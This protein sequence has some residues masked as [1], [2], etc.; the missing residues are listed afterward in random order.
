MSPKGLV[1]SFYNRL[2]K[3]VLE[4][5]YT[6]MNTEI[7]NYTPMI[8]A[9]NYWIFKH[10]GN[11]RT[12]PQNFVAYKYKAGSSESP[13][14]LFC[15]YPPAEKL[16]VSKMTGYSGIGYLKTDRAI[17]M[18]TEMKPATGNSFVAVKWK[19][20]NI[21]LNLADFQSAEGEFYTKAGEEIEKEQNKPAKIKESEC[22]RIEH[23]IAVEKKRML[24]EQQD[25]LSKT[26]R[27]N[28]L[29]DSKVKNAMAA[30]QDPTR[31][32]IQNRLETELRLCKL[33]DRM[34]KQSTTELD[35]RKKECLE[36]Q[37]GDSADATAESEA[38]DAQYGL[39]K[40]QA[41]PKKRDLYKKFTHKRTKE[42]M[43]VL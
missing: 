36:T 5:K 25:L 27:G 20:V 15:G 14:F 31:G 39:N 28:M 30:M 34:N 13:T 33:I 40:V 22:S 21:S 29:N 38:I 35:K 16:K 18:V 1:L 37:L 23:E 6:T 24:T 8:P 2:K 3:G 43:K 10:S 7:A 11:L 26:T 19:E 32:L 12:L 4:K 41:L 9:S 42:C 17:Y